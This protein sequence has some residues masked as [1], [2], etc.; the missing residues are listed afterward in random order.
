VHAIQNARK[1]AGLEITDRISLSLGGDE[2]LVEAARAHED[3]VAGEVL[4][5]QVSYGDGGRSGEV[6]LE[7]KSLS[8]G[9][10][11]A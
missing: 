4:A 8:I 5:T 7:G 9:V 3:Y 6:S 2:D 10:A 1:Q 11:R